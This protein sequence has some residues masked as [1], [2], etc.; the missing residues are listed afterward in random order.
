MGY[1]TPKVVRSFSDA[2]AEFDDI[3]TC[4]GELAA[5]LSDAADAL[6]CDPETLDRM[7]VNDWPDL[8][9]LL[10]LRE[11]WIERRNA[12]L[13]AWRDLDPKGRASHPLP[14]FGA[15]DRSRPLV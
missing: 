12:L 5:M 13:A 14:P 11:T 3:E 10:Q 6:S 9:S 2:R 4:L 15:V 7:S 1:A 8:N